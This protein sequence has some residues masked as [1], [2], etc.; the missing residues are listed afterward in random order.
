MWVFVDVLVCGCVGVRMWVFVDVLVCG[1]VGGCVC[2]CVG[3]GGECFTYI[4]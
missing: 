1:C 4:I 2:M 3:G